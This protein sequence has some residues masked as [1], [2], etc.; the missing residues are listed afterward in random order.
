M[1]NQ[2]LRNAILAFVVVTLLYTIYQTATGG[3]YL[4]DTPKKENVT[5]V[6]I[7]Y[8][9]VA[10]EAKEYTDSE[11]IELA[12]NLPSFC[13]YSVF[14]IPDETEDPLVTVTYVLESGETVSLAVN[15]TTVWWDGNTYDLKEEEPAVLLTQGVF[16]YDETTAEE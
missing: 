16:F 5:K 13:R 14:G 6:I 4:S 8:P 7:E 3:L 10:E 11:N 1:K 15:N 2:M 12:C 9:D